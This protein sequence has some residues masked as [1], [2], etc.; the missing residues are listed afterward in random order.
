VRGSYD[1][2]RRLGA[3]LHTLFPWGFVDGNLHPYATEGA[4]TIAFEI[5]EQLD[6]QLPDA[7]VCPAATGILL[8]KLAQGFAEARTAGLVSG[9]PPRVYGAQPAGASPIASA[10]ADDRG[11]SRVTADTRVW[12][13]AVG[14]PSYGELAIGAARSTDGAIV[15]VPEADVARHTDLLAQTT[16][17]FADTAG[18]V[19]LAG[20]LDMVA[21]GAIEP[22]ARVVLVVTGAGVKPHGHTDAP[23]V[24]EVDA[25]VDALLRGL[26][27]TG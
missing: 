10:Y 23:T 16:G 17:I 7:I 6:W 20:L 3:E 1:D 19:A 27:V 4:K 9:T 8:S 5:A 11:V 26:D 15:A 25:D 12:S 18:G 22:G 2:C 21:S 14:D 24:V 13:L